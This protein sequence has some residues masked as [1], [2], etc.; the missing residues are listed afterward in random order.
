MKTSQ[1]EGILG[2]KSE[3]YL[4]GDILSG[5]LDSEKYQSTKKDGKY[6][7]GFGEKRISAFSDAI[8]SISNGNIGWNASIRADNIK[9][10]NL[11]SLTND[12]QKSISILEGLIYDTNQNYKDNEIETYSLAISILASGYNLSID[13]GRLSTDKEYLNELKNN[14]CLALEDIN[15]N[16]S[17]GYYG[18]FTT[19]IN[20]AAIL[21]KDELISR[22]YKTLS[23]NYS[24]GMKFEGYDANGN[25]VTRNGSTVKAVYDYG[26]D[27]SSLTVTYKDKNGE[28]NTVED[29]S[30]HDAKSTSKILE[31]LGIDSSEN[32]YFNG[33]NEY[34][35]KINK[36]NSDEYALK[37]DNSYFIIP[38]QNNFSILGVS[39]KKLKY[40]DVKKMYEDNELLSFAKSVVEGIF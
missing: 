18:D 6:N 12:A 35:D 13:S 40:K 21:T 38:V 28:T 8:H 22:Q 33:D 5:Q 23:T 39:Y 32:Y 31:Y 9:N 10:G 30:I 20:T 19:I 16:S 15:R 37:G 4:V 36:F 17:A 25:I 2:L 27:L 24:D 26:G 34:I 14:I 11:G 29:I 3:G 7:D 1:P